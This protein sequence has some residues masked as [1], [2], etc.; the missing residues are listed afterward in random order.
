MAGR[1]VRISSAELREFT[2]VLSR[3]NNDLAQNSALLGAK[4]RQLG[5]TWQDPQYARFAQEFD[6]TMRNLQSFRAR[7]DEVIPRLLKLAE[8]IDNVPNV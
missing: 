5:E 6:Q 4:F 2:A 8:Y 1:V 3:F 7:S